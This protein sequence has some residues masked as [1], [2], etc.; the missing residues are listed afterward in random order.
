MA[1]YQDPS[2]PARYHLAF[3]PPRTHRIDFDDSRTDASVAADDHQLSPLLSQT[4]LVNELMKVWQQIP[5]Q[6]F[7]SDGSQLYLYAVIGLS[8]YRMYPL[9]RPGSIVQI[10]PRRKPGKRQVYANEYE[11][12][13]YFVETRDESVCCWC[14]LVADRLILQ[15]HPTAPYPVRELHTQEAEVLGRVSAI[16]VKLDTTARCKFGAEG[17]SC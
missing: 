1:L 16:A 13:L 4:Q 17:Y 9:L 5:V 3:S 10:D 7:R 12:P 11:R 2:I 8:D 6:L 14:D 15:P